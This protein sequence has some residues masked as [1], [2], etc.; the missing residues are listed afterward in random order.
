MKSEFDIKLL[1]IGKGYNIWL[2]FFTVYINEFYDC[3]MLQK[4][5]KRIRSF[6]KVKIKTQ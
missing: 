2:L 1:F 5:L 3:F 4:N 6:Q